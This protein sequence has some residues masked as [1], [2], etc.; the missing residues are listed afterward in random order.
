L[1]FDA[2]VRMG[3]FVRF[4]TG[5]LCLSAVLLAS[6][7][8]SV[9]N[10]DEHS[11]T[12]T[13][14]PAV[15]PSPQTAVSVSASPPSATLLLGQSQSFSATVAHD[16]KDQGVSWSLSCP[17]PYCGT[18]SA[19]SSASG[20]PISYTAPP[21]MPTS[22]VIILTATS[23]FDSAKSSIATITLV[24]PVSVAVSPTSSSVQPTQA[25]NFTAVVQNDSQ[26]KG[27]TWSLAG[28]GC[29]GASCGTLSNAS[30]PA[31]MPVTYTAPQSIPTP[32]MVTLTATSVA[33]GSRAASAAITITAA[34]APIAVTVSPTSKTLIVETTQA[35]TATVQNDSQNRGVTWTLSGAG[36]KGANCGTLSSASTPSGAAITYTAPKKSPNPPQV[37][38]TAASVSDTA[39]TANAAITIMA[40]PV[41]I[42][43]SISPATQ[44]LVVRS[45]QAFTA[46]VKNDPQQRG[47]NW[48]LAGAGCSGAS[49][50]SLSSSSSPSGT[51]VT[52]TA[53]STAPNPG[54]IT[55]TATSASDPSASATATI[56]VFGIPSNLSV[57]ISPK[58]GGLPVSQT[59]KFTATV[60]NDPTTQG[61]TWTAS[62][63][64]FTN[65]T[66][67]ST[68][69]HSPASP[70]V[71]TVTATSNIDVTT[72]ASASIGVTDLSGMTTYHNDLARDGVNS[73]EY[74]LTTSN[75]NTSS[76]GKLFSC[77][78]DAAVYAQPLW[79][80]N[81]SI[82]G[83]TH[84]V[85]FAATSH[86]TVYAFDA[87][88]N[89]CITYWS[90]NLMPSNETWPNSVDMGSDDIQPDIG[91]VGTPVI[92]P[93]GK[94]LYVVT[95][96]K[97]IGTNARPAGDCRQRLHALNL[98]NGGETS[99]APIALTSSI[100]VPGS[101]GGS[102]G[103]RL[104]FDPFHENQRP[105]LALV[106]GTL[107]LAW[108]SHTDQQP[109]HGWVIGFDTS[110]LQA[111]PLLFNATPNGM[112]AG[113][114]MA[115]G[116]PSI[117]SD[118]NIYVMTGN[119]DYDGVT[120]F[121]D[122]FLKLNIS[123]SLVDWFTPFDQATM[124]SSNADL[125]SGGAAVLADLPNAPIKHLLIGGGKTGSG[126]A[127]ELY[128]LNRDAMGHLENTGTPIV[129][130][131]P[132][133]RLIFAT[134]AFW[135]NTLYIAGLN[136]AMDAFALDPNAGLF[137]TT[138]TSHS[139]TLFPG[140][141]ATPSVSANGGSH[142]IVWALDNA[143]F[144]PPSTSG[145]G[146]TVLHAY[147]ATNLG[148]ELWNSGQ[149]AASRDVAGNA[150]KF[151][152]PTIANGKVYIGTTTEIDVYGLLPD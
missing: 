19:S 9:P 85:I 30:T 4:A 137:N 31:G 25:Q 38:L 80:A 12:P 39:R 146:P 123:L 28:A 139:V 126:N 114:W 127:G 55:L 6:G 14:P 42:Q 67:S 68:V 132:L 109:W 89:P 106:G 97:L 120:E 125:G 91:I 78:V 72:S 8:A 35:F 76:F 32:P 147:D 130:K 83:G 82:A 21:Q 131:F 11:A 121:G 133:S 22:A 90:K 48:T 134:P 15:T 84:N 3:T 148:R 79:V 104:P 17:S 23:I 119:G 61:V 27:V 93:V 44:T 66:S 135:K 149:A 145:A 111:A 34:P 16:P 36:C 108:G 116:A 105:G 40:A 65:V 103:G 70:G 53:P 33:D 29:S 142:G 107:Y 37:T 5:I 56:T 101:G 100:T 24:P 26:N 7:C 143:Q 74:A 151:T 94:I 98:S 140:K 46:T 63:G 20:T 62:A 128:V 60:Q 124:N 138:P 117:D 73:Q 2:G 52:Y 51:P 71:Y 18:L 75:V 144:G 122:S 87:D 99:G 54:T 112:G 129:Q 59:M 81:V 86:N 118:N 58:R 115:G 95:K 136:G 102:T 47:V 10:S 92:D 57:T 43:V 41:P 69:Y 49:C 1:N 45:S 64:T 150:V 141:G 50:G 113:I 77:T 152:V 13:D 88:A 110:N 96:S